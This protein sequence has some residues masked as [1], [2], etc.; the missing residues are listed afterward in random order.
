MVVVVAVVVVVVVVVVAV[1]A[2]NSFDSLLLL[3]RDSSPWLVAP[4]G[5]RG[6]GPSGWPCCCISLHGKQSKKR[7][8]GGNERSSFNVLAASPDQA[9]HRS[10]SGAGRPPQTV[11][12]HVRPP[13]VF[14]CRRSKLLG[15]KTKRNYGRI[16][17]SAALFL[18]PFPVYISLLSSS[19][20]RPFD[21]SSGFPSRRRR[22]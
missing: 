19:R 5:R 17:S 15:C 6:A 3:T 10:C 22:R 16:E 21:A 7:H 2:A 11:Y 12:V 14:G 9:S 1:E 8:H 13:V 20:D 18:L 4:S